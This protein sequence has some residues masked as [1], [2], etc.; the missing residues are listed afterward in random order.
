M[1]VMNHS[2]RFLGDRRPGN[3]VA[4]VVLLAAMLA[5][6]M[7]MLGQ[8]NPSEARAPAVTPTDAAGGLFECGL[9][10]SGGPFAGEFLFG[11]SD[12]G[13]GV[14]MKGFGGGVLWLDRGVLRG[15]GGQGDVTFFGERKTY[16]RG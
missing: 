8:T 7:P 6:G 14:E 11:W 1:T 3:G 16:P 5:P 4:N 10:D 12:S 13:D 15:E 2:N 9:C